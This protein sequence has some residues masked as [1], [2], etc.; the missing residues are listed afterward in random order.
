MSSMNA[1][2]VAIARGAFELIR[3]AGQ[4]TTTAAAVDASG[5][6]CPAGSASAACWS[7][8]GAVNHVAVIDHGTPVADPNL[9]GWRDLLKAL[10]GQGARHDTP[11]ETALRMLKTAAGRGS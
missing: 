1:V 10:D 11:R 2:S 6:H 3:D 7:L 8:L 9:D 5:E 4:H